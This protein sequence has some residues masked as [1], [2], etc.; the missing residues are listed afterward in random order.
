MILFLGTEASLLGLKSAFSSLGNPN[1]P[2]LHME[3]LNCL[4]ELST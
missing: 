1:T 3:P 4:T 2:S